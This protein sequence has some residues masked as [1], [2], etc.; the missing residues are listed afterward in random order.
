MS[1]RAPQ[2]RVREHLPANFD[3][4]KRT[5]SQVSSLIGQLQAKETTSS[6]KLKI[7]GLRVQELPIGSPEANSP[8]EGVRDNASSSLLLTPIAKRPSAAGGIKAAGEQSSD[9]SLVAESPHKSSK[10]LGLLSQIQEYELRISEVDSAIGSLKAGKSACDVISHQNELISQAGLFSKQ[11]IATI[12]RSETS[13]VCI[14]SGRVKEVYPAPT[15]AGI[16]TDYDARSD[17]QDQ[18][19]VLCNLMEQVASLEE[20]SA[21]LQLSLKKAGTERKKAQ[22]LEALFEEKLKASQLEQRAAE[23]SRC[24][25]RDLRTSLDEAEA[26]EEEL[27]RLHASLSRGQESSRKDYPRYQQFK[28]A[29]NGS[30]LRLPTLSSTQLP[31]SEEQGMFTTSHG[32]RAA[33]DRRFTSKNRLFNHAVRD[34]KAGTF[35]ELTSIK[36][37]ER[38]KTQAGPRPGAHQSRVSSSIDRYKQNSTIKKRES[39]FTGNSTPPQLASRG[40]RGTSKIMTAFGE[41]QSQTLNQDTYEELKANEDSDQK[42]TLFRMTSIDPAVQATIESTREFLPSLTQKGSIQIQNDTDDQNQKEKS[43]LIIKIDQEYRRIYEFDSVANTQVQ[44]NQQEHKDGRPVALKYISDSGLISSFHDPLPASTLSPAKR[45]AFYN[46]ISNLINRGELRFESGTRRPRERQ[47]TTH[48]LNL[49]EIEETMQEDNDTKVNKKS[50]KKISS[51]NLLKGSSATEGLSMSIPLEEG[52]KYSLAGLNQSS[53]K[54]P[55]LDSLTAKNIRPQKAGVRHSVKDVGLAKRNIAKGTVKSSSYS[56]LKPTQLGI[57]DMTKTNLVGS[58]LNLKS[59]EFKGVMDS[60]GKSISE[61]SQFSRQRPTGV[62][63]GQTSLEGSRKNMLDTEIKEEDN[64]KGSVSQVRQASCVFIPLAYARETISSESN[65]MAS[66][67]SRYIG[68]QIGSA[69]KMQ[70]YHKKVTESEHDNMRTLHGNFNRG[71]SLLRDND[72]RMA[73]LNSINDNN[74]SEYSRFR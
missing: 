61:V 6:V 37:A 63:A 72:A 25:D 33:G 46:S 1:Q 14:D 73:S 43:G 10:V 22:L 45:V 17:Y 35:Q 68:E 18:L 12:S 31:M 67:N 47:F 52:P 28:L 58:S 65:D 54:S 16:E 51:E 5:C 8:A 27:Q 49:D 38:R 60:K 32:V 66:R 11:P 24:I 15:N 7:K 21:G 39:T 59:G 9:Y 2:E 26:L 57:L 56:D 71:I 55:L 3:R 23:Q 19:L 53:F 62:Y 34:T 70:N 29:Q 69:D 13:K 30:K 44:E 64:N 4:F 36:N 42:K 20:E 50:S 74:S 40:R 41:N 48:L